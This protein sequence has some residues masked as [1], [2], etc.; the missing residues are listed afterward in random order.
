MADSLTFNL[1]ICR[2][3]SDLCE[4]ILPFVA[5]EMLVRG[6]DA[7]RRSLSEQV[8]TFFEMVFNRSAAVGIRGAIQ[9]S[10][11][12]CPKKCPKKYCDLLTL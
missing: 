3:Q 8:A 2:L 12:K 7:V 6:S 11:L 10:P 5:H 9:Y 4:T 1:Y